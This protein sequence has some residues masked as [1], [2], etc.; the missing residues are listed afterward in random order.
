MLTTCCSPARRPSK[1]STLLTSAAAAAVAGLLMAASPASA[2]PIYYVADL[3]PLNNSGVTG[4]VNLTLDG[5]MLTVTEHATGLEA[6]MPHPQHIH[7]QL[8]AAAPNT[9][10]PTAASDADHDGFIELAE[11]RTTYGPI[12]VDLSSPPGGAV[13]DFPTAPGGVIDF[14]Q[15]YDLTSPTTF[16]AGFTANDL[17]PLTNRE[18][19]IHG[20][21]VAAGIG[22]GTPGEGERDRRLSRDAAGGRR[23]HPLGRHARACLRRHRSDGLARRLG[24]A[25][26][27]E[28][29]RVAASD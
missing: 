6:S 19:V 17:L 22:A 9:A 14:T 11:G 2:A 5:N 28:A 1:R 4:T 3:T 12:L 29:P 13:A 27:A 15:T 23:A 21:T 24:D 7:G 16:D 8:G 20:L 25:R 10:L 18:I 26:P